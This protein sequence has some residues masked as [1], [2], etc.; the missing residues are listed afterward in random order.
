MPHKQLKVRILG[1]LGKGV[2]F[3]PGEVPV[4]EDEL[5]AATA[6]GFSEVPDSRHLAFERDD[7]VV[8]RHQPVDGVDEKSRAYHLYIKTRDA[9]GKLTGNLRALDIKDGH[10]ASHTLETVFGKA[11][12]HV[13]K[14]H[15]PEGRG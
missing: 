6:P 11:A 1:T 5:T 10:A 2:K 8:V 12:M 4:F 14:K 9:D 3:L 13:G 7:I 15:K